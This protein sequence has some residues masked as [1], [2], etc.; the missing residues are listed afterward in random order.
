MVKWI[1]F[2]HSHLHEKH[3]FLI[4]INELYFKFGYP[5]P[6]QNVKNSKKDPSFQ[7]LITPEIFYL[8]R[9]GW[10]YGFAV[11]HFCKKFSW[12]SPQAGADER[13]FRDADA[14]VGVAAMIWK[15]VSV[16]RL[17]V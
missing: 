12:R 1:H 7:I 10:A 8:V 9:G 4:V 17:H 6:L 16:R 3:A 2:E 11:I 14:A 5:E 15:A 13:G